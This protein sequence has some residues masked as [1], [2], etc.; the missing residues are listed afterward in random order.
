MH[1]QP[2][3]CLTVAA[4]NGTLEVSRSMWNG[5]GCSTQHELT[6][7]TDNPDELKSCMHDIDGMERQLEAFLA[8]AAAW[9]SGGRLEADVEAEAAKGAPE[10]GM[11]DLA[12]ME[13]MLRSAEHGA[14][15][16]V[17]SL[18]GENPVLAYLKSAT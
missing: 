8:A 12:I 3:M 17:H 2:R 15:V 14:A 1:V 9:R 13:A 11:L 16:P 7:H 10:Q 4:T 6:Y 5:K 18:R